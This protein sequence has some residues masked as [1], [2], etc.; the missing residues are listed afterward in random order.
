MLQIPNLISRNKESH[1][2]I[3]TDLVLRVLVFH[4]KALTNRIFDKLANILN[5]EVSA[6][7]K[8]RVK[9]APATSG[10]V[11]DGAVLRFEKI[12]KLS[13]F[14]P[15]APKNFYEGVT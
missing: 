12:F 13:F 1:T 11:G 14:F 3:C 7:W 9:V 4:S 8:K 2:I 15:K 5:A 10:W 6:S